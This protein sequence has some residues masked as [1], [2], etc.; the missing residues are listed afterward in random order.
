MYRRTRARIDL[1]AV[2]ANFRLAARL[3]PGSRNIAVI[4][5]NAYGHG[6]LAVADAL[7]ELAPA[8]AV[9]I[10]EEA[11]E[12]RDHGVSKPLLV[13]EGVYSDAALAEAAAK[14]LILMLHAPEQLDLLLAAKLEAPPALWL[15]VDTGMHRLGLAPDA[16]LP[17]LD[18]LR[19]AALVATPP[20]VCT[21]LA[22][23]DAR[24]NPQTERQLGVF[25]TLTR[26][27]DLPLS[28]ANS[29]GI[30]AWPDSHSDWNRPGYMLFGDSPLRKAVA[31]AEELEPAMHFEA[32]LI[33]VREIAAGE[34]VGYG[35]RWCAERPSTI[36]TVAV[37]YAD[38]YP[39]HA[40]DGTPTRVGGAIAPLVGIVSMDMIT[41]DLTDVPHARPGDLVTLWGEGLPIATVAEHVGSTGYELLTRVSERVPRVY[42]S[43]RNVDST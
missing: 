23:A 18:A 17:T 14:D 2:R 20:V 8:Y 15:K 25:D 10:L 5:G 12:L 1:D 40:P 16:L 37:G 31:A 32:E 43:A 34:A 26:G 7:D 22:S 4:K 27:L 21:H 38:G 11:I 13:L 28:I 3:A 19:A 42:V 30:L 6:M 41:V 33:A 29:A 36:G 35:G 9:A 24:E 39:R